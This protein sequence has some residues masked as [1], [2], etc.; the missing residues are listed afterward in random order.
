LPAVGTLACQVVSTERRGARS[1]VSIRAGSFV[2]PEL[3][4]SGSGFS[5]TRTV[6]MCFHEPSAGTA[7][8]AAV[9]VDADEP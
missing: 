6:D 4:E 9:R 5:R 8:E 1:A 7:R 3:V 2:A